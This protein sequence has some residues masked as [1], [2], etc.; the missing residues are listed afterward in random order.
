[1]IFEK[2][3]TIGGLCR[4]VRPDG[5][6]FDY[7]GHFFHCSN[8]DIMHQLHSIMQRSSL[9]SHIRRSYVYSHDTYTPY[10][11]QTNLYGLPVQTIVDCI[12]GF[13]HRKNKHKNGTFDSWVNHHFGAGFAE[14]FFFPYQEKIFDFPV[15]K[16][17]TGWVQGVPQTSLED[18]LQG[19]VQERDVHSIGYN[20]QFWYPQ[21]GGIDHL[22]HAYAAAL[23]NQIITNCS[24]VYIDQHKK[25][26]TFS[27]GHAEP[28]EYLVSTIPLNHVLPLIGMQAQAK[29][30]LCNSVINVNLGI[31]GDQIC[32]K[33]WIYYPEKHYTFFRIGFPHSLGSMAPEGCSSLSIEI[34][35]LAPLTQ[36]KI[37]AL[38]KAAIAHVCNIFKFKTKDIMTEQTLILP[39]A[40]VIY[41]AW[42]EKHIDTILH[43]MAQNS[44][45]S[46]GR[47]G[48]WK[49]SSMH[50]AVTDGKAMATQLIA[51]MANVYKPAQLAHQEQAQI[52]T[53]PQRYPSK[54][55]EHV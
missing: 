52:P 22:I 19:A 15:T 25:T 28:Y 10:P 51:L 39:H 31:K 27:N 9:T 1:V 4:S 14:H 50:D 55:S 44:L 46:I 20:A 35:K 43:Y 32:N 49:Y 29:K 6:T 47:F 21:H 41:D 18:I 45:Y 36:A 5:F 30:L 8:Q 24:A 40:Y 2:E 34:A 16:L 23:K 3:A 11:Y 37:G 38:K 54:R 13:V 33:H 42:R 53:K 17:R 48:A 12:T 7:T 26:V